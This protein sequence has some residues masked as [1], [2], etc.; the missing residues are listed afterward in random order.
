MKLICA[1]K[2]CEKKKTSVV[3]KFMC[4]L[5]DELKNPLELCYS[6]FIYTSNVVLLF[7][8]T[9]LLSEYDPRLS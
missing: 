1:S 9:M 4:L 3:I 7:L 2:R 6:V 8:I 5:N